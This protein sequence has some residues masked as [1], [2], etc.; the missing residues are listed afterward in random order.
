MEAVTVD[1]ISYLVRRVSQLALVVFLA[2]SL[3]FLIPRLIPGDPV[4][5]AIIRLQVQSGSRSFD[6][7]KI[8][9]TYRAKFGLDRPIF[10]QYLS[11]LDD[12]SRGDLGVSFSDFPEPVST[13]IRNAL[14]WTLGLLGLSTV[15]AFTIGSLLGGMFA[16]PGAGRATRFATSALMLISSVPFYLLAIV[17]VYLLA[18]AW[19]I[20]PA[21]GGFDTVRIP[22]V[23]VGTAVDVLRHAFLPA[24]AIVLGSVGL[25]AL[26]MRSLMVSV[27]GEDYMTFAAAKGLAPRRIFV[28][29]GLRNALLPQITALALAL[30]SVM[31]GSVLVEVIFNYPGLGTLLF[32][33]IAGK[34]YFVIQGVV[35]MLIIALSVSLFL[36]DLLYPILDPRI[37]R[38]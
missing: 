37:R 1:L 13:K 24:L 8:A 27:L 36:I 6:A 34:D 5:T 19:A 22:R 21:A 28:W 12:L 9:A 10:D 31:S 23:D 4:Q 3:N 17:L 7:Q 16:L 38:R 30:G 20:F 18:V 35:L 32:R 26:G 11:Y 14:P 15:I 29:Y 25:W 2:V 33:A